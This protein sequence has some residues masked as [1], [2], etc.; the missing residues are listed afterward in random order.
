MIKSVAQALPTYVMSCLLLPQETIKKLQGAISKF[1][2]GTKQ[3]NR[4]LH[5][6]AWDKISVSTEERGLGFRDLKNFNLALLAKQLWRIF[7]YPSSFLAM[8]LKGRY[9]WYSNPLEVGKANS[10]SYGWKSMMAAR[11][12]LI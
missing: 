1:W 2:W 9:Y 12:L 4:G 10:P 8:I 6:I 7:H 3:N 5:W 11:E